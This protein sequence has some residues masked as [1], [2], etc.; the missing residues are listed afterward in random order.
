MAEETTGALLAWGAA[1]LPLRDGIP[2]P[3]REALW[4]LARAW[5]RTETRVR[6]EPHATVPPPVAARFREWVARR[7]HGEPAHH[8]TGTCPFW[9]REFRV[10]PDVLVPRPETELIV[11]AALVA[12]DPDPPAVLDAGTGS[13]CLAVT[14]ALERPHWSV[15][16]CDLSLRALTIA[17]AN[18]RRLAAPVRLVGSDL[19]SAFSGPFGLV[20]ANLPY[21]PSAAL[22][23]LPVEVRHDPSL[24]LDGG[25]DGLA[26]VRR[27]VADLPR[28]LAPGG[29]ALLEVGEGQAAA[30]RAFLPG[31]LTWRGAITD[32]GGAERIVDIVRNP[33][34]R[35]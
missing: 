7:A 15:T 20:V 34:P 14:L 9:S 2:D 35:R 12:P 23:N 16:A 26:L 10:T 13:G 3:R 17:A 24:A 27:L 28:I 33:E 29:R 30:I 8:L 18:A 21:V 25:P 1:R 32:P 5:G 6:L 19:A 22:A 4:L 11:E 31:S